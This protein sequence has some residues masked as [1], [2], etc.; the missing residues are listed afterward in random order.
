MVY[1]PN[2]G[3]PADDHTGAGWQA[4]IRD[5]SEV[6]DLIFIESAMTLHD[7]IIA[8]LV[9]ANPRLRTH[10]FAKAVNGWCE[11][12]LDRELLARVI[13]D[14][15]EICPDTRTVRL[16]EVVVTSGLTLQKLRVITQIWD[17]L[18]E[19]GVFLELVIVGKGGVVTHHIHDYTL[20]DLHFHLSYGCAALGDPRLDVD[21]ILYRAN[22]WE[23]N[24]PNPR[25]RHPGEEFA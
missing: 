4:L 20:Q 12:C 21:A 11:D 8:S 17:D 7:K 16:Y 3:A 1:P 19:V 18:T 14:A 13:P 15:F 9:K 5:V 22:N 10:G 25:Q 6:V 23:G 24:V 2:T